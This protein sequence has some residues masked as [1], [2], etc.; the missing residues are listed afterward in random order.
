MKYEGYSVSNKL[1]AF[2]FQNVPNTISV[3]YVVRLAMN[4]KERKN[5]WR[6]RDGEH[7]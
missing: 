1:F 2:D 5:N 6:R 3:L 4:T 7:M